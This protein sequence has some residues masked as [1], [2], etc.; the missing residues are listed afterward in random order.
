VS[1]P[2][3]SMHIC[4]CYYVLVQSLTDQTFVLSFGQAIMHCFVAMLVR[5]SAGLV[6]YCKLSAFV[7]TVGCVEAHDLEY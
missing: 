1:G 4:V 3:S 2:C 5:E 7:H 6:A